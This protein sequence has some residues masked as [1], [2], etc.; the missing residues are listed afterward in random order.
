[1]GEF[2]IERIENDENNAEG[3]RCPAND[4]NLLIA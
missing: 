1:M 2:V 4:C 3:Y